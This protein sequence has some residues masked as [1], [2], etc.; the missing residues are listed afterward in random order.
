MNILILNWRDPKN[1]LSGGA[2]YVTYMHAKAWVAAGFGVTWFTSSFSKAKPM[3]MIDEITIIRKGTSLTVFFYAFLYYI[4]HASSFDRLVD[5]VHGIPFFAK[6]YS[7][8]PVIVFVHEVA[9]IIWDAMYPWPVSTLGKL[10]ERLYIWVYKN[11]YF[12]TDAQ[13][14]KNELVALGVRKNKCIVIPCP[15]EDVPTIQSVSKASHP[16]FL[17]VGRIVPMKGVKDI[18]FA[19]QNILY[20]LPNAKLW[21]VG[22]GDSRYTQSL[23]EVAKKLHIDSRIVW[24]GKVHK[25]KKYELM[26]H[27]HILLHAS[28]KEG[29]G[30]VVLEAARCGTPTVAYP[31]G[32]LL[33]TVVHG[34]TGML[35]SNAAYSE[36]AQ[37]AILVYKNKQLYSKLV[38]NGLPWSTSF[39]WDKSTDQSI[40]LLQS[41]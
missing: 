5:E 7:R 24:W 11:H 31:S 34:Q 39:T 15:I 10:F 32:G 3:E 40:R 12:W 29:W 36:L 4:R 33:D 20:A 37:L 41:V 18:L 13:T 35:T 2:E 6:L 23:R 21:I 8:V 1:P 28:V 19:F 38:Q 22:D 27:A 30:L 26:R 9:G 17:F 14:T 25:T 16:T